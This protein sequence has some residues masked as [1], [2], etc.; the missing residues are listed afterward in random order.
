[1]ALVG[2]VG[3]VGT[4]A[5]ASAVSGGGA[6]GLNG[7]C[8]GGFSAVVSGAGYLAACRSRTGGWS[9][10]QAEINK[11][12][13]SASDSHNFIIWLDEVYTAS[14]SM[15]VGV[16][17]QLILQKPFARRFRILF[18]QWNHPGKF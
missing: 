8:V 12:M 9:S 11:A 17:A 2:A 18:E 6:F 15:P 4:G 1:V 5:L 13:S 7:C 10:V 14:I 3:G 16:E